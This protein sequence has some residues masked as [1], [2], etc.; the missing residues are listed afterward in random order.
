MSHA[1]YMRKNL[2]FGVGCL[3]QMVPIRKEVFLENGL[4]NY[5]L[6]SN[7]TCQAPGLGSIPLLCAILGE[8]TLITF[9]P[10]RGFRK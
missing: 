1:V 4:L 2:I 6:T 5:R 10:E 7:L 8:H 3:K 9:I